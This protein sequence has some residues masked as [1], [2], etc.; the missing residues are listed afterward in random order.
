MC[1]VLI[2]ARKTLK[3][4]RYSVP[5]DDGFRFALLFKKRLSTF[6]W[7][8]LHSQNKMLAHSDEGQEITKGGAR[9]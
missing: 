7:K 9:N 1:V 4:I 8:P 3:V 5:P 2:A 6:L